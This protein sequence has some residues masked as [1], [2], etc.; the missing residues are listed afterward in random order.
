AGVVAAVGNNGQGGA[1]V[2]FDAGL[3]RLYYTGGSA[4]IAAAFLHRNDL[5]SVK[6]SSW[7]PSDNG[8]VRTMS[9]IERAAIEQSIL[10]GRGGKGEIFVWAGGNGAT[11]NDRADYDPYT[12]S[13]FTIAVAAIDSADEASI[14][15]EPGS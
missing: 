6:N 15:S 11:N 13:R 1:G 14:Y 5:I 9:S 2:A 7:G 12:T 4:A 3:G 10:T 8:I